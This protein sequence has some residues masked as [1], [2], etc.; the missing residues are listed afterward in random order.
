[1]WLKQLFLEEALTIDGNPIGIGTW[2]EYRGYPVQVMHIR[3][4]FNH[5]YG[6]RVSDRQLPDANGVIHGDRTIGVAPWEI[7]GQS[8][9]DWSLSDAYKM[10]ELKFIPDI[11]EYSKSKNYQW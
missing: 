8:I 9:D 10:G 4:P 7:Q 5:R 6:F 1:V 2:I 3:G 11:S